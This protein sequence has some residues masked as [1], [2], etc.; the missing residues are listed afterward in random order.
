MLSDT[1][2]TLRELAIFFL[3]TWP[4]TCCKQISMN[5]KLELTQFYAINQW[6]AAND[7]CGATQNQAP[8]SNA[9]FFFFETQKNQNRWEIYSSSKPIKIS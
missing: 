1:T 8:K 6:S 4:I 5:L 2:Q 7:T 3:D 9:Y